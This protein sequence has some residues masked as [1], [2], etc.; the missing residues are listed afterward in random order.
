MIYFGEP[1]NDM[2]QTLQRVPVPDCPC[3]W[4]QE[5]FIETDQGLG[6]PDALSE[7]FT[8]YHPNCFL[9]TIL[10]SLGHQQ[11]KCSCYGGETE[12][13]PEMTLRE[14]ADAAVAEYASKN[15]QSMANFK[16]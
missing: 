6:I 14:A 9:R 2:T 11:K 13:P 1:W 3:D 10:G 15:I 4:C 7:N 8:Y 12:D 16:F 5:K